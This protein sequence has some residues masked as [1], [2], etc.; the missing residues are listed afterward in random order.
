M[1]ARNPIFSAIA[2]IATAVVMVSLQAGTALAQNSCKGIAK[3]KCESS[4]SCSWVNSYKTKTGT[5]VNAYCRA[6]SSKGAAKATDKS[7]KKAETK[8]KTKTTAAKDK[9]KKATKATSDKKKSASKKTTDT[10]KKS[11]QKVVDTKK[12]ATQSGKTVS[13]SADKLDPSKPAKPKVIQK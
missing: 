12:K 5:T 13:T 4:A 8:T 9:A 1:I 7:T 2:A 10:K 6:K 11:T 3:S